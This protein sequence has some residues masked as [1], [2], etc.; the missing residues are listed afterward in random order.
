LPGFLLVVDKKIEHTLLTFFF[1]PGRMSF[2]AGCCGGDLLVRV[3]FRFFGPGL[4]V[5][6]VD[7]GRRLGSWITKK[8]TYADN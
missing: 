5:I 7:N 6:I 8:E 4:R 2:H 3:Y 1:V